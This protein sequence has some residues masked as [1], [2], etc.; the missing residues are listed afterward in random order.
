MEPNNKIGSR[1]ISKRRRSAM[2]RRAFSLSEYA[3]GI[4]TAVANLSVA[5]FLVI[6]LLAAPSFVRATTLPFGRI[7]KNA[8]QQASQSP[9][10]SL[11]QPA[12]HM[13]AGSTAAAAGFVTPTLE[14]MPLSYYLRI[15]LAGGLA[16]ATGS[17]V[18]YP[19]DSAKTLRQSNPTA[20]SSVRDALWTMLKSKNALR[21]VYRG[22]LPA[23]LGAIPSSALY[24]GAYESSKVTLKRLVF[25]KNHKNVDSDDYRARLFV[26]GLA[27]AS[28]N[29]ISSFVFVP[30]EVI[31]QQLQ[32]RASEATTGTV[33]A[34]GSIVRQN[35]IS[36]LYAGYGATLLRNIPSA[37]IRF[38]LYEELKR[39][40]ATAPSGESGSSPQTQKLRAA[41]TFL[42]GAVA[43]ATSS[44]AM[45]PIDVV[46]TRMATGSCPL[47]VRSCMLHVVGEVGWKG[48]YAGAG[49][50]VLWSGAFSAIGFGT[51]ELVKGY[52]GVS[53]TSS[54][55]SPS[56]STK[57]TPFTTAKT[58]SS[59]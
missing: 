49:S 8:P 47:G 56:T 2:A 11:K 27:A 38:V 26:H 10:S 1:R 7:T 14:L 55:L 6:L 22:I 40:W 39:K 34:I 32:I 42:A 24:F 23:A 53:S 51:F 50:R 35:G 59:L 52:L 41:G 13:R 54:K 21:R 25:Q 16:G 37:T 3:N 18:L 58:S 20:Y 17:A 48:L 30:K 31:K 36:G 46:K 9:L 19:I 12:F 44:F 4:G 57:P 5:F 43:G 29:V 28:G 15:A 33:Q 45:T